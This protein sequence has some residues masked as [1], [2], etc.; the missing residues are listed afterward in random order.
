VVVV[1]VDVPVLVVPLVVVVVDMD[2]TVQWMGWMVSM[3]WEVAWSK[4]ETWQSAATMQGCWWLGV[5][6]MISVVVVPF[7]EMSSWVGHGCP[8]LVEVALAEETVPWTVEVPNGW[9]DS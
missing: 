7:W 1:E 6:W 9:V 2:W 5:V 8:V 3:A 4:V